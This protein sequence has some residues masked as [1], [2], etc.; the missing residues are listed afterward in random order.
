MDMMQGYFKLLNEE[1]QK[2]YLIK[3]KD[4]EILKRRKQNLK[5]ESKNTYYKLCKQMI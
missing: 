3:N 2:Y 4:M 1:K 5:I